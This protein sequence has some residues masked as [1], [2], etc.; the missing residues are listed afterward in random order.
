MATSTFDRRIVIK[1]KKAA[2]ILF[3]ALENPVK[4]KPKYNAQEM[5]DKLEEGAKILTRLSH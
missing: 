5:A 1:S 4:I 2:E 3:K